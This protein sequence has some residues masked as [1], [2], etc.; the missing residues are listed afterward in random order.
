MKGRGMKIG[1][2]LLLIILGI[3]AVVA[4]VFPPA[5]ILGLFLGIAPGII[6]TIAPSAFTY[7]A[8]TLVL[9][10]V[11]K[12][13]KTPFPTTV[14]LVLLIALGCLA[15][16]TLNIPIYN[17]VKE[18]ESKDVALEDQFKIPD[19]IAIYS[20]QYRRHKDACNALCQG[21]LYNKVAHKVLVITDPSVV[22][23]ISNQQVTSYE[24]Q[25]GKNCTNGYIISK[26][27]G[28]IARANVESRLAAGE[29][30]VK[31][32]TKILEADVIFFNDNISVN[33]GYQKYKSLNRR[34]VFIDYIA[35][36]KNMGG[37]FDTIYRYSEILAQ[38]FAY[39]L[40]FGHILGGSGGNMSLNFGFFHTTKTVNN[41]GPSYGN[42]IQE[43]KPQMEKIFEKALKP[44][45]AAKLIQGNL[46][47]NH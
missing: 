34:V 37:Q 29:C 44:I 6:L 41:P 8:L 5:I 17:K 40:S 39:P 2:T 24:I 23:S 26:R 16:F 13:C 28:K 32:Q 7:Y 3:L 21:L 12:F 25:L 47:K 35:L 10:I 4:I 46:Q 9:G 33:E 14:S 31:T 43:F 20:K 30:L 15:S 18:Y 1:K 42:P 38:P 36:L 27:W 11:L 22:D 19:T 45:E